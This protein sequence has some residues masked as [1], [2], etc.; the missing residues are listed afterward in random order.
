MTEPQIVLAVDG[1]GS[2]TDVALLRGDGRVLSAVRGPGSS[3]HHLGLEPA[4]DVVEALVSAA[5]T[6]A[7]LDVLD[8]QRA[9][10]AAVFMAGADL[11]EEERRLGA[12]IDA[13]G[14]AARSEVANDGF[15][16]LW[17]ATGDGVGIAVTVGSGMNCVGR[18]ADGRRAWFPALGSI[19]G[20]WGG[21]A[22]IGLAA[23]GAAVRSDDLRGPA[24][25]LSRAVSEHF[26]G[27]SALEVAVAI[28][29]GRLAQDRLRELA[30]AVLS[31]AEQ[32]DGEALAI[33]RRQAEAV[34]TFI[35][36]AVQ[37]LQVA[38]EEVDIVLG[39]GILASLASATLQ[40]IRGAISTLAP[41]ARVSVCRAR[42][43]LGAALAGLHMVGGDPA[44]AAL[45]RRELSDTRIR[46]VRSRA[47]TERP[48]D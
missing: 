8:G 4:L 23:L 18:L 24:T 2:K 28:H 37:Q 27:A 12:A 41:R 19:T 48:T 35:R 40:Q 26:G 43:V 21:G 36:G 39:G 7:G 25:A 3:P 16:L 31:L 45:A 11:P 1:G 14:W 10:V 5:G 13:R 47:P 17:A 6:E 44:A 34:A 9:A 32:G 42:P 30:P 22:D 29:Q 15:A 20:D 33:V 46:P 38:G